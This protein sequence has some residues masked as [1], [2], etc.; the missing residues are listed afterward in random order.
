MSIEKKVKQTG[1]RLVYTTAFLASLIG[2]INEQDTVPANPSSTEVVQT[3]ENQIITYARNQLGQQYIF[4]GRNTDRFPGLDCMGLCFQ[5]YANVYDEK[6]YKYSYIPSELISSGKLGE[7]I[8]LEDNTISLENISKL[9]PG[10]IIYFLDS[11]NMGLTQEDV[12]GRNKPI[13]QINGRDY[14]AY[15]M[16][17]YSGEGNILHA[18]PWDSK[19]VEQPLIEFKNSFKIIAT[20]R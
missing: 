17:I 10:D 7:K 12:E 14:W 16:A 15:H 20:R 8:T 2:G 18:S 5:A 1:K 19:V 4:N 3:L 9:H 11:G 13:E 6:W